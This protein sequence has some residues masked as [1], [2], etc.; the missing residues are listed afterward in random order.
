M[1]IN[2]Y[3]IAPIDAGIRTDLKSWLI[4]DQAFERLTNAYIFRGRVKKRFG[5]KQ[6][7]TTYN[8]YPYVSCC[9][10]QKVGVLDGAGTIG[11]IGPQVAPGTHWTTGQ[12]FVVGP[13]ASN[14]FTKFTVTTLGAAAME[15]DLGSGNFN[16]AT[17]MFDITYLAMAGKDVFYYPAEPVMG[18]L[19][20]ETSDIND[21]TTYAFDRQF[22][23]RYSLG[24]WIRVGTA[25]WTGSDAEIF[26]GTTYRG[27]DAS[28]GLLFVTNN[29]SGDP[30]RY[31][32][33]TTWTD[34][35]PRYGSTIVDKIL[36]CRLIVSFKGRLLLFNTLESYDV[37]LPPHINPVAAISRHINRL[38]YSLNGTAL[39]YT[40][41]NT[42]EYVYSFDSVIPGRGGYIDCPTREAIITC[43]FLKDRLIVFCEQSTWEV[44]YTGNEILPFVWQQIDTSL[45]AEST[46]S[47]VPFDKITIGIGN[48]GIHACNGA[49]VERID[50]NIPM[51]VFNIHNESDGPQRVVGI[52]DF[53]NE[54]IYWSYPYLNSDAVYPNKILVYNYKA[55]TW[56]INEDS[57]TCFGYF[58]SAETPT[59]E[60][61]HFTWEEFTQIWNYEADA[62]KHRDI[63]AGN[64][65][66][67][68]VRLDS[69][70]TGMMN[71]ESLHITN[72]VGNTM[73]IYNHNLPDGEFIRLSRTNEI[74][75]V[76][77]LTKDTITTSLEAPI[78]YRSND[79][80][81]RVSRVDILT[82][83]YNF[84]SDKG[85]NSA[86]NRIDFYM[87]KTTNGEFAVDYNVSSSSLFL[88]D[89]AQASNALL[90]SNSIETSANSLVPLETYQ[91]RVWRS[92][93]L[94]SDGMTVQVRIYFS[95]EQMEALE[96]HQNTFELHAMLFF[97]SPTSMNMN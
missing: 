10:G 21:E 87:S 47:V 36:T 54:L 46:F 2:R 72:W 74:V 19:T 37:S 11:V 83:E 60:N 44:V 49:N 86:V 41:P 94:T 25:T 22:A 16:T 56:A 80:V 62:P 23:Y 84:F 69:N 34:F 77:V 7:S 85:R 64:Q 93:Y 82:K 90:G 59:W 26:W 13:N 91:D 17:G 40:D 71:S 66:G 6:M 88:V 92:M 53:D 45:G 65:Q 24:R 15:S 39:N 4:P 79:I 31:A 12:Y 95:D 51:E 20:Y 58:Q 38:R 78:P 68:V 96:T 27:T 28:T 42:A 18:L 67:W 70:S 63:A 55:G 35:Q 1:A 30:M 33:G 32:T 75:S 3:L 61:S 8:N 57:F 9:L 29:S 14:E 48:V 97:A 73:T 52:R 81:S 76:K 89:E 43:E 50:Q 5:S